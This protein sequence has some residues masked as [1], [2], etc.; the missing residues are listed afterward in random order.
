[1]TP[2]RPEITA[3]EL[4]ETVGEM[5]DTLEHLRQWIYGTDLGFTVVAYTE[6]NPVTVYKCILRA[7]RNLRTIADSLPKR[8]S[9]RIPVVE[10]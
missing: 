1:M 9:V 8:R 6:S 3:T 2:D 5:A 4:A 7:S 10:P